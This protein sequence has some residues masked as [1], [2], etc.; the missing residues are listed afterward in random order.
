MTLRAL[1]V[2]D[3]ALARTVL[4]R[5]LLPHRDYIEIVGEASHGQEA[6]ELTRATVIGSR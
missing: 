4:R 3:E 1:I 2:D 6:L 5:L